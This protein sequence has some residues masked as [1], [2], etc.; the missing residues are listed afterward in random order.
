MKILAAIIVLLI[1]LT[2][3]AFAEEVSLEPEPFGHNIFVNQNRS[4]QVNISD[5]NRLINYGDRILIR[6]WGAVSSEE[7][8]M[9]NADGSIFIPEVGPIRIAGQTVSQTQE[10]IKE[11]IAKVYKENVGV[12]ATLADI[13]PISVFVTGNANSPG[14]YD[15]NQN[16]TI[17][18]FL[19]KANGINPD[20]GSY[21]EIRILRNNQIMQEVDIYEFLSEGILPNF[22]FQDGDT[23]VITDIKNTITIK[24]GSLNNFK[25]E[26]LDSELNGSFISMLAKP[27]PKS[28]HVEV[29]RTE[30]NQ[31]RIVNLDIDAFNGSSLVSGDV[32]SFYNDNTEST[33]SITVEGATNGQ[34]QFSVSKTTSLKELLSF[35]RVDEYYADISSIH[36]ERQSVAKAQ[37]EALDSSLFRLQ[38]SALRT[39]PKSP[40]EAQVRTAEAEMISNFV[41]TAKNIEFSGKVVVNHNGV[42]SD[43]MLEDGDK[44]IIPQKTNIIMLTGEVMMP[45]AFVFSSSLSIRDYVFKSG[46][47]TDNA[48]TNRIVINHRDGT[49]TIGDMSSKIKEGDTIIIMPTVDEKEFIFAKE[50]I[51]VIYQLAVGANILLS[52]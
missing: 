13:K 39:Q 4:I 46:G 33:I 43:L 28:T 36:I 34:S 25:F 35:V 48:D 24:D 17:I 41:E 6:T 5:P 2:S 51:G 32:L 27:Q 10:T 18:D 1:S 3:F 29:S 38:Q 22:K 16:D 44:I 21:R 30:R 42:K 9:V 45:N 15:G 14:R 52:I 47:F 31:N 49:S 20:S 37:K 40:S 11:S 19:I 8:I 23:I 12:Y 26:L 7:L 50:L